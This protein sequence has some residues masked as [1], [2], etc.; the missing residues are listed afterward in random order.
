MV[1]RQSTKPC[2][3]DLASLAV[4]DKR[5]H[6]QLRLQQG[7]RRWQQHILP[8]GSRQDRGGQQISLS[9]QRGE[10]GQFRIGKQIGAFD[11]DMRDAASLAGENFVARP[12]DML[13]GAKLDLTRPGEI[14]Q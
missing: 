10:I 8:F 6:R 11:I 2:S 9:E 1:A 13:A 14:R 5:G 4:V 12:D 7:H 3:R